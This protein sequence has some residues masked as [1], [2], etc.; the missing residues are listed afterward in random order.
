VLIWLSGEYLVPARSRLYIG[1][2]PSAGGVL[3]VCARS[4][5]PMSRD[6]VTAIEDLITISS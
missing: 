5:A 2:S 4:P 1:Q 6:T 3:L